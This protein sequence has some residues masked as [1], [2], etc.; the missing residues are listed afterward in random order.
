M[1]RLLPVLLLCV[2]LKPF[3]LAQSTA[4]E[5]RSWIAKSNTYTQQLLDIS[6]R[7]SPEGASDEG[8]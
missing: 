3:A 8:A 1:P 7:H 6:N 2:L 5:D 4:P